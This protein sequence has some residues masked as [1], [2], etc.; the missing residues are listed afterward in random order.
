MLIKASWILSDVI[1]RH[2]QLNFMETNIR[3]EVGGLAEVG[4]AMVDCL[5]K[6]CKQLT[7]CYQEINDEFKKARE[8]W[9]A[10]S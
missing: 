9:I 5:L 7:H 1:T 6:H 2:P 10:N 8:E 4:T 3:I